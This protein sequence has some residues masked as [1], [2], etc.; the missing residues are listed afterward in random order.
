MKALFKQYKIPILFTVVVLIGAAIYLAGRPKNQTA[1]SIY[2]SRINSLNIQSSEA[3]ITQDYQQLNDDLLT[4]DK[5]TDSEK[6]TCLNQLQKRYYEISAAYLKQTFLSISS[7]NTYL[8]V[9]KQ[10]QLIDLKH[11]FNSNFLPLE[12]DNS[13]IE[14]RIKEIEDEIKELSIEIQWAKRFS[15]IKEKIEENITNGTYKIVKQGFC[16]TTF[17]GFRYIDFTF[18]DSAI[19][20]EKNRE[21]RIKYNVDFDLNFDCPLVGKS[22]ETQNE[23][24]TTK[25]NC[26]INQDG[27]LNIQIAE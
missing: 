16:K 6:S 27:K 8:I 20:S 23:Q 9:E 22:T 5:L 7:D 21:Y 26:S 4:T 17:S 12:L 18:I 19:I 14:Q 3:F 25:V 15:L 13:L 2:E 1:I 11:E 10:Q 24:T